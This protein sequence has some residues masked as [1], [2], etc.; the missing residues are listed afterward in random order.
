MGGTE[1]G[2]TRLKDLG[3]EKN[4]GCWACMD[5]GRDKRKLKKAEE[6][7][8]CIGGLPHRQAF[9]QAT[10]EGISLLLT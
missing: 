7:T 6:E 5:T 10:K 9:N 4:G 1:M 3:M 8:I 2:R